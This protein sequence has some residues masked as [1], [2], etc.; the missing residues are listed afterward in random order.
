MYLSEDL[1]DSSHTMKTVSL[2]NLY[3]QKMYSYKLYQES[4]QKIVFQY[5]EL[6][7]YGQKFTLMIYGDHPTFLYLRKMIAQQQPPLPVISRLGPF[8]I[9]LNLATNAGIYFNHIYSC[10]KNRVYVGTLSAQPS[11]Q[12]INPLNQV[13]LAAWIPI[14]REVLNT[15]KLSKDPEYQSVYFLLEEVLPLAMLAYSTVFRSGAIEE[16]EQILQRFNLLFI[17]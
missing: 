10:I 8:D 2:L 14:R 15:F 11:L 4:I 5:P 3:D 6:T 13:I 9:L 12:E 16:W 17:T 7:E 1:S